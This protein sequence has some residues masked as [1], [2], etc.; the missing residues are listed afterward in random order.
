MDRAKDI[1]A[2]PPNV[3]AE[4]DG[5]RNKIGDA[6]KFV[7]L[8]FPEYTPHDDARHLD[9]LFSIADRVMDKPAYDR[10]NPT[11]LVLLAFGLYGHDWGMAL[12]E[13]ERQAIEAGATSADFVFL[14]DE[15]AQYR[16]FMAKAAQAGTAHED[17][18]REYVRD[19]HGLRSGARLRRELDPLGA[20]FAE[21]VARIAEGHAMDALSI[22][23]THKY[24]WTYSV[25]GET[26]NI[27]ALAEYVRI[28]DLLDI[29][30][31][32]TPFY[33]WRFVA[34][35]DKISR[36]EWNKHRAL[37]PVSVRRDHVP[38]ELVVSGQTSD[39]AL[40]AALKDLQSWVDE[41]FLASIT[42]IRNMPIQYDLGIDSRITW[43]IDAQ[44]FVPRVARFEC[45]RSQVLNLLSAQ[46]YKHDPLA[47]IR[48][49]LQNSVDAIDMRQA[50]LAKHGTTLAGE[51]V[52]RIDATDTGLRVRWSDNGIG[53]D[54]D[55]L[56]TYFAN[57][58]KSWYASREAAQLAEMEPISKFGVGILSCFAV[59]RTMK[60]ETR[61]DP[62]AS[63]SSGTPDGLLVTIPTLESHFRI[64]SGSPSPVGT[65]V[66]IDV[67]PG[68]SH[69]LTRQDL[70]SAIARISRYVRH[71]ITIK[72]DNATSHHGIG[73]TRSAIARGDADAVGIR[74]PVGNMRFSQSD[75]LGRLCETVQFE[76]GDESRDYQGFYSAVIPKQPR[77]VTKKLVYVAGEW[78]LGDENL[79]LDDLVIGPEQ[80]VFVKGIQSGPVWKGGR[81]PP[82]Y[83]GLGLGSR[84]SDWIAP[85]VLVNFPRSSAVEFNLERTSARLLSDATMSNVWREIAA[86]LR[87]AANFGSS[88]TDADVAHL[89]GA[90]ALFGG[91]PDEGL[92]SLIT[93]ESVPLLLLGADGAITWR[94]VCQLVVS[95]RIIEAP[96][97][98]TYALFDDFPKID[99]Q[100][101]L[102]G[103]AGGEVMLPPCLR[104]PT[105]CPWLD[106]VSAYGRNTLM[107][108]G[109]RP[110]GL[111]AL[112][113]PEAEMVPLICRV[114][115]VSGPDDTTGHAR[116]AAMRWNELRAIC[117][118]APEL[119]RFP[120]GMEG[121]AAIGSRYWNAE[122]PKIQRVAAALKEL[123]RR[124][125]AGTLSPDNSQL[126]DYLT[127]NKYIGYVVPCRYTGRRLGIEMPNR[128]L[129]IAAAEG[130]HGTDRLVEAD[131]Y[132]GTL[133]TYANP[134]H[135]DL[136]TWRDRHSPVGLPCAP[137][138]GH[139]S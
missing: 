29:G 7:A 18:W 89:L 16:Q 115:E 73:E 133:G 9:S 117:E 103:W 28:V 119:F 56:S 77:S 132:P 34:P 97:E 102:E 70:V 17:S 109:W 74:A 128:L 14:H 100:V 46:L 79:V 58:G 99:G 61:K 138:P 93:A 106:S 71:R 33:L 49:L 57:A 76:F 94:K 8:T 82:H 31:D 62:T 121:F 59:S 60:I 126:F 48:E 135:Y 27:A 91:I 80:E 75:V 21:A 85:T 101:F 13:A 1:P 114:W 35:T 23:D 43:N 118:D 92:D 44:G 129:D 65:T 40:Y 5:L 88:E 55:V 136:A 12:S 104:S 110:S 25:W 26:A 2:G 6:V 123:A 139:E 68:V 15:P 10:L 20:M 90:C 47:F 83:R 64:Q 3:V 131:F 19:T 98:L 95:G 67:Q 72:S 37:S 96:F 54:L 30:D 63:S 86:R 36:I 127:G 42:H 113:P 53:M 24:S 112:A 51:I 116:P 122:H 38:R 41:N 66:E 45:D 84:H 87:D 78:L 11:E 22:K 108:L 105:H 69:G 130:L 137:F 50:L 81:R 107:N 4:F 32:R 134:Y 111:L 125:R 124:R 52:V 120:S 39:P